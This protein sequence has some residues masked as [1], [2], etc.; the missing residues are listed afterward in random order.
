MLDAILRRL[1]VTEHHGGR[2][3]EPELGTS[4]ARKN[5]SIKLSRDEGHTWPVNRTLEAGPSM[6]SDLAVTRAGTILCFYGSSAT[7]GFAG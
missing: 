7:P 6:Y 2:G 5:V 3:G 1:D 4:R